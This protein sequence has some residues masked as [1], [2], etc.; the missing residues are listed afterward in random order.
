M[1]TYKVV[2]LLAAVLAISVRAEE[3]MFLG[4]DHEPGFINLDKGGDL[5]YWL[6]KSRTN[7]KEDPLVFWL[8]GGPGCASEVALFS[9]NGPFTIDRET[10]KLKINEYSWSNNSNIIF[11]DQPRGTGF[12]Q[13]NGSYVV[14]EN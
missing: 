3:D 13:A 11:I 7:P 10:L 5:F 14:N 1:N 9:E 8:T 6:F 2:L 12:S 4:E